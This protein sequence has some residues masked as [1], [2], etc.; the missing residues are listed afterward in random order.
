MIKLLY[1]RYV[2]IFKKKQHFFLDI[3]SGAM[4]MYRQAIH[5]Y[6]FYSRGVC[7]SVF[8]MNIKGNQI[9]R[10]EVRRA[11]LNLTMYI[12]MSHV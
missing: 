7:V 4:L 9:I 3:F 12:N 11:K 8:W 6:L 5:V 2:D 10:D 1:V